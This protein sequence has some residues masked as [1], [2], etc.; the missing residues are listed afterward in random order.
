[1]G[2]IKA[3]G[4]AFKERNNYFHKLYGLQKEK[5]F[6]IW[7]AQDSLE[8]QNNVL[9]CLNFISEERFTSLKDASLMSRVHEQLENALQSYQP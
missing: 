2:A 8:W 3:F 9:E 6:G 7:K 4:D 1:M 5:L